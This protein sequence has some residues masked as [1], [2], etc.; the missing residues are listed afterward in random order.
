MNTLLLQLAAPLQ[1][2]GTES[3]FERRATGR[4]PSKSGV[5]GLL[6][7]ALGRRRDESLEDLVGL[8]FGVRVVQ[9]G[10]VMMDFHIARSLKQN[11][12]TRRYY[13]EDAVFL[14]GLEGEVAFLRM[15]DAAVKAPYFPLY[16]GRRSCPPTG[17]ISLGIRD[18]SLKEALQNEPFES[19][20]KRDELS[21]MVLYL[22][23]DEVGTYRQ[24]DVPISFSQE[25][26][27]FTYRYI[28]SDVV[29]V[30]CRTEHNAFEGMGK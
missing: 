1:S 26:R 22:D 23:T 18:M 17:R 3:K 29:I 5:I 25:H 15:L 21:K 8:K 4:E 2:W 13:L 11:Y 19:D 24:R 12:V 14:V 30:G 9:Q 28:K 20:A 7:A 10:Q 16:L 6:A 27:R